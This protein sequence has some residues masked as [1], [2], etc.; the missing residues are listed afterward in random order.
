MPGLLLGRAPAGLT[1]APLPT[2]VALDTIA[3]CPIVCGMRATA[4]PRSRPGCKPC[5][6][7]SN[8]E[9]RE[10]CCYSRGRC[11]RQQPVSPPYWPL[12]CPA[13]PDR[14]IVRDAWKQQS[15]SRPRAAGIRLGDCA[16][17][18]PGDCAHRRVRHFNRKPVQQYRLQR[19]IGRHFFTTQRPVRGLCPQRVVAFL[20]TRF[21]PRAAGVPGHLDCP[22]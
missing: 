20:Q 6:R 4:V 1:W 2:L 14:R 18:G 22:A 16:C 5:A 19:L 3:C 7:S 8:R 12:Q 15:P 17:G 9:V 11:E 21:P 10:D 13:D